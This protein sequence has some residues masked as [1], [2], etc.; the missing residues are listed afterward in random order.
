MT[1]TLKSSLGAVWI[2]PDGPNTVPVYMG[3]VDLGDVDQPNFSIALMQCFGE[4]GGWITRG[5]L[6]TAPGPVTAQ[7]DQLVT[8]ARSYLNKITSPFSLFYMLRDKGRPDIFNNYVR[9]NILTNVNLLNYQTSGWVNHLEDTQAME[10]FPLNADNP[11]IATAQ[12]LNDRM[13]SG[14]NAALN[15]IVFRPEPILWNQIGPG[16]VPGMFGIVGSDGGAGAGNV[17][18]TS[19]KGAL[20]TA[21]ATDPFG[22]GLHIIAARGFF[23]TA[24]GVR[25]L[26]AKLFIGGAQGLV[27]FTDD[28][29]TTWTP[30]NIGGVAAG[31]GAAGSESL[32]VVN[33]Y[34]ILLGSAAGFIYRSTDSGATWTVVESG[35]IMVNQW[36]SIFMENAMSGMAGGSADEIAVTNDGGLSWSAAT[37]TGGGSAINSLWKSGEF[38][39]AAT[40]N[41]RLYYSSNNGVTWTRRQGFTGD[42]IGAITDMQ[43]ANS[44]VGWITHNTAAPIGYV[45]RTLNGGYSWEDLP[46]KTNTGLNGL[47][48]VDHN[49]A[50]A[51]GEVTG[52][53]AVIQRYLAM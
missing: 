48:V 32:C 34:Q 8:S 13:P 2:Q 41:G 43:W 1:D 51:V 33:Q 5:Q 28:N 42:G 35:A 29:G 4:M 15:C 10:K 11:I 6:Y 14:E 47:H 39:W 23:V 9:A 53:T 26:V 18:Y 31:H 44:M 7:L 3:C 21:S 46:Y 27:A 37:A 49:Q 45:R 40:A 30:I 12:I 25:Y 24:T 17:S 52:T 20:W 19:N 22:V 16:F 50:W 36:K 38:W